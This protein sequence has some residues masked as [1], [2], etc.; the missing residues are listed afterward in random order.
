MTITKEKCLT[1][2][3][4]A[5]IKKFLDYHPLEADTSREDGVVLTDDWA[6]VMYLLQEYSGGGYWSATLGIM[7]FWR[8]LGC[9]CNVPYGNEI[10]KLLRDQQIYNYN[11]S[12]NVPAILKEISKIVDD[13]LD[14]NGK[15]NSNLRELGFILEVIN[16]K[17]G[18]KLEKTEFE[19]KE[20]QQIVPTQSSLRQTRRSFVNSSSLQD[21]GYQ[22]VTFN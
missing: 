9:R 7:A 6:R 3:N 20:I 16:E 15:L 4:N 12:R 5:P 11:N 2:W 18:F 10:G 8:A 13:D 1:L 14:Q 22:E 21:R 19:S 17:T